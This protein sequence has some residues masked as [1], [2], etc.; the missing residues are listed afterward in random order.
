MNTDSYGEP[1]QRGK[2]GRLRFPGL[3]GGSRT[4]IMGAGGLT[5]IC[6]VWYG[7]VKSLGV[8]YY[9]VPS[10]IDVAVAV[11]NDYALL[12]ANVWPTVLEAFFGFLLG[13]IFAIIVAIS[14]VYN[15]LLEELFY[16]VAILIK[17]IPIV[18]IAPVLKIILGNG[19]EPKIA[20]AAL[21]SFFPT[22]VNAVRGFQAVNPQLLE[23]LHVLSASKSEVFIRIRIYSALPYVFSALK[24]SVTM[25]VLG[26]IVGEWIGANNGLGYLILQSMFNFDTPRLFAT[27]GLASLIAIVG[28]GIISYL[29]KRVI[30]WD[31][32][33][34][35]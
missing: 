1:I 28:F 3:S 32:G 12:A 16:P 22:L 23:L 35:L 18:A 27:I 8:P 30:R 25:S 26:A 10:P 31:P 9:L 20:V 33:V 34:S 15:K 13:N 7:I 19:I 17:T 29:E 6:L 14:F 24:I 2:A 4:I 5:I 21:I 11:R